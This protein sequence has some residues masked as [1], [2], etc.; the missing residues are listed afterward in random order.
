MPRKFWI[1]GVI[2]VLILSL[3]GFVFIRG[4]KETQAKLVIETTPQATVF[5]NGEQVGTTPFTVEREVDE[6]TIKLIPFAQNS[7]LVPYETKVALVGGME[8][9]VR[10]NFGE[11]DDVSSGEVL[12]FEKTGGKNSAIT[13]VS[14]P[15]SAEISLDGTSRGFTPLKIDTEV[16]QHSLVVSSAGFNPR[17][18]NVRTLAGYKLTSVIKL[19]KLVDM[20]P[21][22]ESTT[23]AEAKKEPQ[24]QVEILT[25]PTGFLRV[26]NEPS[27]AAS[28][29]ARVTPGQKYT[30]LDESK[31][32]SWFKI[33]YEASNSSS[34]WISAQYAKKLVN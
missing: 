29:S 14:S 21:L 7:A 2:L 11:S 8:T 25:T 27:T 33:E 19:A 18:L 17:E 26:R 6:V 3:A 20:L 10:R 28:E 22:N 4:T 1:I 5:L 13:L 16:G 31:D 30:L 9:V 24:T 12:F 34:G 15:D 32:G 23:S